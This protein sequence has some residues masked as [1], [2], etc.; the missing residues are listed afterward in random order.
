MTQL[1]HDD[2][3]SEVRARPD[4]GPSGGSPDWARGHNGV[5]IEADQAHVA[6]CASLR[7]VTESAPVQ[8]KLTVFR[9]MARETAAHSAAHRQQMIDDLWFVAEGLGLVALVGITSVQEVLAT[10]F[11]G[12]AS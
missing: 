10:A 7:R 9:M 6:M 8:N 4:G 11:A 1:A 12:S 3:D 5:D 2:G